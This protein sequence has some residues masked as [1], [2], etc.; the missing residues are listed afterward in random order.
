MTKSN[1]TYELPRIEEFA[2]KIKS[3]VQLTEAEVAVIK[4]ADDFTDICRLHA[5]W[6]NS[7]SEPSLPVQGK[8]A[9]FQGL[10][11]RGLSLAQLDLRGADFTA[12]NLEGVNMRHALLDFADFTDANLNAADLTGAR[13]SEAI[14]TGVKWDPKVAAPA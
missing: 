12:A 14:T 6:L 1:A 4:N 10:D 11:M 5:I 9:S 7:L 2:E 13:L 3:M 8:R